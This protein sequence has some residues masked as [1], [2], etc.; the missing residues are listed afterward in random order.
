LGDQQTG[1]EE[2]VKTKVGRKEFPPS[3]KKQEYAGFREEPVKI[4]KIPVIRK[5]HVH[6]CF[7]I[8]I[9]LQRKS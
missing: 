7:L 6:I 1:K 2:G 4:R 8:Q 3:P 9:S 5:A